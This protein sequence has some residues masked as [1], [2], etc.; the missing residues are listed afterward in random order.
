M[1]KY[2]EVAQ[3]KRA[4]KSLK[5]KGYYKRGRSYYAAEGL[6]CHYDLYIMKD[7][8][9]KLLAY[10]VSYHRY[11][12]LLRAYLDGTLNNVPAYVLQNYTTNGYN[13]RS[14]LFKNY[15]KKRSRIEKI[16]FSHAEVLGG[17]NS[18]AE[19]EARLRIRNIDNY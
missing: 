2:I 19:H 5:T 14:G 8:G 4:E 3:Y 6:P 17:Y 16:A 7:G 1:E 9:P 15:D 13:T 18:A 11:K 12:V 10:N